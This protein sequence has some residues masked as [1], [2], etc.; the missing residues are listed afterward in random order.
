[1]KREVALFADIFQTCFLEADIV[2]I[3]HAIDA[4]HLVPLLEQA[5][6]AV[7]ADKTGAAGN[8]DF[9]RALS[10]TVAAVQTVCHTACSA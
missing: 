1:M 7:H 2:V 6:G 3:V 4:D 10:S 5:H 8:Q 9:H